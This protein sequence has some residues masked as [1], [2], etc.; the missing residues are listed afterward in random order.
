ML[1]GVYKTCA[2]KERTLLITMLD[3]RMPGLNKCLLWSKHKRKIN[4]TACIAY[5]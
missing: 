3:L 5:E 2:S 1:N 4:G